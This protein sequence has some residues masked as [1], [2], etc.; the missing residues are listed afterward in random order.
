V[1]R[2]CSTPSWL[3]SRVPIGCAEISTERQV[4][5]VQ[6]A[7]VAAVEYN[8]S[9]RLCVAAMNTFI[10][11][12]HDL[13]Q[14]AYGLAFFTLG[15]A[16][17]LHSRQHSRQQLAHSLSWL[18]A[19]GFAHSFNEWGDLF[20]PIQAEYLRPPVVVALLIVQLMLLGASFACLM[21]FGITLL[22]PSGRWRLL[23]GLAMGLLMAWLLI[24]FL[25]SPAVYSGRR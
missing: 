8:P 11:L 21:E 2:T 4:G 14:F 19:F 24:I 1:R 23:H 15:L 12:N 7:A 3:L 16:I 13:I 22:R 5:V 18:A 10:A 9:R 17:A 25:H 6:R 20:I